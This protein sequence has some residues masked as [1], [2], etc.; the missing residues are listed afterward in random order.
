MSQRSLSGVS[1]FVILCTIIYAGIL[2]KNLIAEYSTL[3]QLREDRAEINKINYGLF[4]LQLWKTEAMAVFQNRIQDFEIAPSA[5]QEVEKELEKYLRNIYRDYIESGRIF[6]GIFEK[7]EQNEAVNKFFLRMIK[8][9]VGEQIKNLHI[10]KFI[11]GMAH[12]LALELKKQ[13]PRIKEVMQQELKK[14][15][16]DEDGPRSEDPRMKIYEKYGLTCMDDTNS[17]LDRQIDEY[18]LNTQKRIKTLYILLLAILTFILITYKWLTVKYAISLATLTSI[19]FLIAGVTLPMIDLEALLNAFYLNVLGTQIGFDYQV[20]YFQ[21]KSILDVTSTL[22]KSK[23]TDLKIVGL[24][25]L[26]FSIVF[27]FFKLV[28]SAMYF[29][30]ERLQKSRLV[31]NLIF[32][33]GKWSMA[34]VFVVAMFMAYIGFYGLVTAQLGDIGRNESGFA[35]ETINKSRL[36]PGAL[37]FTSYCILSIIT[38]I[39]IQK[40]SITQ[41]ES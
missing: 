7:A 32:Y 12:E 15:L 3:T 1:A 23:G 20:I 25:I 5:Y 14:M 16:K 24:M 21:S 41:R 19:V 27:P 10:Q 34:D 6:S 37:F 17:Y 29:F 31:Q 4:N 8:D 18:Q 35:V 39:I 33:L 36:S 26:A 38:G 30:S 9:N 13:E 40:I 11:P 2:A 28:L 22:L